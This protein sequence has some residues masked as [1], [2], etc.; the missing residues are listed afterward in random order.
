MRSLLAILLLLVVQD[1]SAQALSDAQVTEAIELGRAGNVPVVHVGTFL[2]V[3]QGDFNV[4]IEG[5]VARIAAA[6]SKAFR[7][8]CPFDITNVTPDMKAAIYRVVFEREYR[9]G[10]SA[11]LSTP[12]GDVKHVVLQPKRA[13]G[14]DGVIQPIREEIGFN[15]AFFDRLPDVDF[16]VVI[17]AES[18]TQRFGVDAKDRGK[19][20]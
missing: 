14:M 19:I 9:T 2:G 4:F 3:T 8:Y 17:V 6:S 18:T 10:Y 11:S 7:E 15:Q 5:P 13:K 1:V 12:V 16:D 20:R